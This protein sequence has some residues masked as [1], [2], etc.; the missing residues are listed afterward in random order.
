MSSAV[1]GAKPTPGAGVAGSAA[2]TLPSDGI[3]R[4]YFSG[5]PCTTP[6]FVGAS[7]G[8]LKTGSVSR[9]KRMW[10]MP[11]AT[12]VDEVDG[13]PERSGAVPQMCSTNPS[14]DENWYG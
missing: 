11:F 1:R 9:G 3:L 2:G 10:C 7:M 14:K 6:C 13:R 8:K 5:T 12:R 4:K